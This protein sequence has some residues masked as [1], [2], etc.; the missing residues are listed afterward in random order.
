MNV[1]LLD[2]KAQFVTIGEDVRAAVD[3]VLE[4]QRFVLGNEGRALEDELSRYCRTSYAIGCASGSDALLLALMSCGVSA[5]DEVVTTPFTFF[6][7]AAA[8]TRPITWMQPELVKPF[9]RGRVPSSRYICTGNALI[10]THSL[11]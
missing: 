9:P 1:P 3:R 7:T 10:W 6:A 11:R 2:L 8:V 5:G 4:S